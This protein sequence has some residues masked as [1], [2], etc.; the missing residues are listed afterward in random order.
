MVVVKKRTLL[1]NVGWRETDR[2]TQTDRQRRV[3]AT[4]VFKCFVV[5][6]DVVVLED[7]VFKSTVRKRHY[8]NIL[9]V[10]ALPLR[11]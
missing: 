9:V 3:A 8:Y 5:V 10:F 6:V 1:Q 7:K 11:K 4:N 2:Q